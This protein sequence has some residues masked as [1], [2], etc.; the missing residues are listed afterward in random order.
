MKS[1]ATVSIHVLRKI[2][3]HLAQAELKRATRGKKEIFVA[4]HHQVASELIG[5][6][7]DS[8]SY[9]ERKFKVKIKVN[10]NSNLHIEEV[11]IS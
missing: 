2:K 3:R 8:L 9:F 5:R 10:P 6:G 11:K 4:V 1:P 7:K